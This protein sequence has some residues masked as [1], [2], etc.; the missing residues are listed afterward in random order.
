MSGFPRPLRTFCALLGASGILVVNAA[1]CLVTGGRASGEL[2]SRFATVHN[3]L[4]AIGM[5]EIG[6]LHDARLQEGQEARIDLDLAT[7]CTTIVAVAGVGVTDLDAALLDATGTRVARGSAHSSEATIRACLDAGGAYTLR[8]KAAHGAGPVLVSTWAG[9]GPVD[10]AAAAARQ[11]ESAQARGTC[12]APLPL[13]AGD[14]TGTTTHGDRENESKNCRSQPAPELVYKLEVPSREKVT[15]AVET[16]K[17]FD[18]VLYVR[19]GDCLDADAEVACNDDASP[20]D[21]RHSRVEQVL[22]AGVYFVFVDGYSGA[23]GAFKMHVDLTDVP[24]LAEVCNQASL[25]T[26]GTPVN[27]GTEGSFDQAGG[28][29]GEGASGPDSLYMLPVNRRSRA[30]IVMHSDDFPPVVHLRAE[31]DDPDSAA[32]CSD[33]GGAEHD[34][35]FVGVLDPGRYAVFA[36]SSQR[37]ASGK[38]TV[39]AELAPE[40]GSGARGERCADAIPLVKT[41]LTV[42]G[43]TFAARDDVAGQCGGTGAPD[44]VY[45][46]DVAARTKL[47]AHLTREEGS[48]ILMLLQGCG[49][50]KAELGCGKALDAVLKPGAYFIAVD[51]E[52]PESFG[53]FSFEW[54]THDTQAQDAACRAPRRLREG[55]TLSGNTGGPGAVDKFSPSCATTDGGGA[56]D[57]VYQL[58]LPS[59]KRIHIRLRPSGWDAVVALRKSCLDGDVAATAASEIECHAEESADVEFDAT[60]D[61]GTYYVV[62]DGKEPSSSGAFTLEYRGH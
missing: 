41:D 9:G 20:G 34:V 31:C 36:D 51:G 16:A 45:R 50:G 32:W 49:G 3:A 53:A 33:S 43:D 42:S 24:S 10:P 44:V 14:F 1:A 15:I 28:S 54:A 13:S 46:L 60:L 57:L 25:L 59:R 27:G 40:L 11:N 18:P 30:R 5:A 62:V 4:T 39:T 58:V 52:S 56:P 35:A 2:E 26:E 6:A 48:H 23:G 61:A 37:G 8:V 21:V 7:G 29:C 55:E 19:R 47:T 12:A 17:N 22:D 38:F